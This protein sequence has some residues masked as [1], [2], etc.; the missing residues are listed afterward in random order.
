L[1][2]R[3]DGQLLEQFATGPDTTAEAAFQALVERHGAMV[4]RVCRGIL[5]NPHDADDA[6]QATFLVLLHKARRL[7]V[8]DSL[9]PWLHQVA[10]RTA[11]NARKER[12]RR[13]RHEQRAGEARASREPVEP[14]CEKLAA[15]LDEEI[16]RLPERFRMAVLLCDLEGRSHEQAAS[17][18]NWPVG[19]LKSRMARGRDR[20]RDR[21][22]RRGCTTACGLAGC[23]AAVGGADTVSADLID[24]TVLMVMKIAIR[25]RSAA[26]IPPAIAG[27]VQGVEQ[28]IFWTSVRELLTPALGATLLLGV[29]WAAATCRT[30]A[31]RQADIATARQR[32]AK[33]AGDTNTKA[34][35]VEVLR[36]S[37]VPLSKRAGRLESGHLENV[38]CEVEGET[39]ILR[40]VPDGSRV[41]RGDTIAQLDSAK[42]RD[43]LIVQQELFG[44]AEA[45]AERQRKAVDVAEIALREYVEGI[46][47]QELASLDAA[48]A[49]AN[50]E[51]ASAARQRARLED[52][53]KIM[54]AALDK[55]GFDGLSPSD[56]LAQVELEERI[57]YNQRRL[58]QTKSTQALV[59]EKKRLFAN[60]TRPKTE[61]QLQVEIARAKAELV[62]ADQTL[63]LEQTTRKKLEKQ[64]AACLVKSPIE[65]IVAYSETTGRH[66]IEEGAQVRERQ[67]LVQIVDMA[68]RLVVITKVEEVNVDRFQTGAPAKITVH[69]FPGR[70][71][72]GT[73]ESIAPLPDPIGNFSDRRKLYSTVIRLDS[74]APEL[75]RGMTV[76]VT[77]PLG[78]LSDVLI[79]PKDAIISFD[80]ERRGRMERRDANGEF[81]EVIVRLGDMNDEWVEIASG[82][83]AGD[84][85]RIN[86][87][88]NPSK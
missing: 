26:G 51:T 66:A 4:L 47:P 57:E 59:G 19:T 33:D 88:R 44:R 15:I 22:L 76:D 10:Y 78:K 24:S 29:G 41:K 62:L 79:V 75:Q 72:T 5:E 11:S 85:L 87:N 81:K 45:A 14:P 82:L 65:G 60:F 70:E 3:T 9:G 37:L 61:K 73:V 80:S 21:L 48:I 52:A 56:V 46:V 43:Q 40:L 31:A 83:N 32:P 67:R 7:W 39:T 16:Q 86:S 58:E 36:G 71:S 38:L 34:D 17:G 6:F 13:T 35:V 49:D 64:I 18:L 27:L 20:L 25:G 12:A 50:A 69:A 23:V 68:S 74:P 8:R 63:Q 53:Q 77:I 42:Q 30:P 2:D 55:R 84:I 54:K 28:M 1:R